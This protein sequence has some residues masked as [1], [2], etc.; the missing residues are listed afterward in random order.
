[1]SPFGAT[2]ATSTSFGAVAFGAPAPAPLFGAPPSSTYGLG[3]TAA[4][5][6][7]A[8]APCGFGASRPAPVIVVGVATASTTPF[9]KP[10]TGGLFGA[11]ASPAFG[12]PSAATSV[13]GSVAAAS[14]CSTKNQSPW[15]DANGERMWPE[16]FGPAEGG[17]DTCDQTKLCPDGGGYEDFT[18][19]PA[20]LDAKIK[21]LD[22][23]GA[24]RSTTIQA[25]NDRWSRRRPVN[26]L[27]P[28]TTSILTRDDIAHETKRA[29]DLIDCLSRSG[30]LPIASSELHVLVA[31]SHCFDKACV[32]AIVVQDNV[33][34]IVEVERSALIL[35]STIFG[36]GVNTI[37]SLIKNEPDAGRLRASFPQLFATLE[38]Q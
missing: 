25:S 16:A 1:M 33:N 3:G 31:V 22:D 21:E 23:D 8:P 36:L 18:S 29:L 4:V 27:L 28:P 5:A 26:L 10:S 14:A 24:L 15:P 9:G 38:K 32:Q 7:G 12:A 35:A 30:T 17:D 19:I 6:F 11:P 34:P 13:F 2:T 37:P 20:A